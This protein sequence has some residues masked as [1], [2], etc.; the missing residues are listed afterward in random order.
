M[1]NFYQCD[2][3]GYIYIMASKKNGTIYTGVTSNLVVRVF[4]HKN[5]IYPDSFTAKYNCNKLVY[6]EVFSTITG[7]IA[8]EKQLKNWERGWKIQ[9]IIKDNPNW[10]DLSTMGCGSSPQ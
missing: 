7:A 1:K 5:K 10:D 3:G 2:Y 8:R 9:L 4:E 6:Y